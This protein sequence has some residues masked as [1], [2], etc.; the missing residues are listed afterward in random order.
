[1]ASGLLLLGCGGPAYE[2]RLSGPWRLVAVDTIGQLNLVWCSSDGSTC[3]GDRLPDLA[4]YAAGSN[5]RFVIVAGHPSTDRFGG[6]NRSVSEF[7]YITRS[8]EEDT[9]LDPKAVK[10]PFDVSL[11]ET[12]KLRVGLPDL[13]RKFP[14]NQ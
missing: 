2:E 7:F 6:F 12:E 10:G 13:S 3:A 14:E 8:Q 11:Y 5:E 9:R 1:M 4:V